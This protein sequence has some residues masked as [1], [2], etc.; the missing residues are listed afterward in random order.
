MIG[1]QCTRAADDSGFDLIIEGGGV[2]LG[3]TT[4]QNTA[5]LLMV[6][7]GELK[8]FPMLGAGINDIIND[9]DLSAWKRTITETLEADG[10]LVNKV[11][12]SGGQLTID[13]KYK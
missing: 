8:E 5:F 11:D 3:E 2:S 6:H 1:L 4:S 7:K 13:S 12:I 9:H 10:Q